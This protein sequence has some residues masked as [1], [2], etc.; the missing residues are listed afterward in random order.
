[1]IPAHN[2]PDGREGSETMAAINDLVSFV[3]NYNAANGGKGCPRDVMRLIGGFDVK[4]IKQAHESGILVASVGGKGGS[5]PEGEKPES[6]DDAPATVKARMAD[7]LRV[8]ANGGTI[9]PSV[10]S[11]LLAEYD[12]QNAARRGPRKVVDTDSAV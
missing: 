6:G 3:R 12:A 4:L 8:I 5:W 9:A 10:A 2:A 1:M 11:D 7:A